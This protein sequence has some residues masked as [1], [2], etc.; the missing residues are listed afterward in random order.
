MNTNSILPWAA[1]ILIFFSSFAVLFWG[2]NV[3]LS[4]NGDFGR[5]MKVNRIT[6][7]EETAHSFL[8]QQTYRMEIQGQGIGE[9]LTFLLSTT[10]E[11]ELYS[12]PHFVFVKASKLMNY[13]YNR[14]T[15]QEISQYHLGFLALIYLVMLAVASWLILRHLPG[16]TL[17]RQIWCMMLILFL[18]CDAGYLLYFQSFY[19][20]GLQFVCLMLA[21]GCWFRL[22]ENAKRPGTWLVLLAAIYFFSGSKLANLPLGAFFTFGSLLLLRKQGRRIRIF[23][24][25]C[26]FLLLVMLTGLVGD[27]PTWMERDTTYQAVFFGIL[28]NSSTP[29]EDLQELGM[30]P[31]YE[32]LANTHAYLETYPIEIQGEPFESDFYQ[33]INKWDVVRFY[34]LHP[35]RLAEKMDIA[36][37]S[38]SSIRPPHLGNSSVM[39]LEH[40]N[41]HSTWSWIRARFEWLYQGVLVACV[42][43]VVTLGSFLSLIRRKHPGWF[44]LFALCTGIWVS[45]VLPIAANGEA[46]LSKHMFLYIHLTDLLLAVGIMAAVYRWKAIFQRLFRHWKRLLL[47]GLLMVILLVPSS[48]L[49]PFS[50]QFGCYQGKPILW[51]VLQED[52]NSITLIS[53]HPVAYLPFD[54]K[55]KNLWSESS[56]R[57]FLNHRFLEEFSAEEVHKLIPVQHR[58]LLSQPNS[59]LA[60]Q[61]TRPHFWSYDSK[62]AA[63]LIDGSFQRQI[64]DLVFLP[65]PEQIADHSEKGEEHWI[66]VPYG[67]N[68]D[69]EWIVRKDGYILFQ[70]VEMSSGVRPVIRIKK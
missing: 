22:Y 60:T 47:F 25:S 63:D 68:S 61:G 17:P 11:D 59:G 67:G 29:K 51:E 27:I 30:D 31:R 33:R 62:Q 66:L 35:N 52:Y 57:N 19:G 23:A 42:L 69:M 14:L 46:D 34:L 28:K 58:E 50:L 38:S 48:S 40:T 55:G 26:C 53:Q 44:C 45:W 6:S 1:A 24:V 12:S 56:L 64:E 13:C 20:E 2:E 10:M 7:E 8:F 32:A 4:D 54:R 39:R 3:G 37:R 16:R 49:R 43:L 36:L 21:V 65:L 9:Q 5:V 18:F 70:D 15:G 41:R